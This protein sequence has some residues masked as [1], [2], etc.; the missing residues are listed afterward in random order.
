[1]VRLDSPSVTGTL[2]GFSCPWHM[3]ALLWRLGKDKHKSVL[4]AAWKSLDSRHIAEQQGHW[5]GL[6][7]QAVPAALKGKGS[8]APLRLAVP[9]CSTLR[10]AQRVLHRG[11]GQTQSS[12]EQGGHRE[13]AN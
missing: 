7:E 6:Q 4:D 10:E 12:R 11:L 3:L 2:P 13:G 8:P 5:C 1:M 9:V